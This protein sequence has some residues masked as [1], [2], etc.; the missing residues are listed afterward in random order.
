MKKSITAIII[1]LIFMT[2]SAS[3]SILGSV[4]KESSSLP[5][6]QGLVLNYNKFLSDQNGVGN[7]SEYYAEYT[8]NTSAVPVVLTGEDIYGKRDANEAIEYMKNN[9]M[10]PMLGINAS[11][12]SFQTGIPMGHVIT[13]GAVTSK[14]NRSLP[15]IGFR[16]DSTAFIEDMYIETNA[17]FGENY[18]LQIPHINKFISSETQMLTLFTP[19]F[20]DKTGVS[21]ETLNVVLENVTDKVRVGSEFKCTVGKIFKSSEPVELKQGQYVLSVNTNGNQW[22]ITLIN[23]MYE[24]EEITVRTT[25]GNEIWNEAYNGLASEGEQIL[26]KGKVAEGLEAGASPRT[27]VGIK[28]NGNIIFYVIDGRQYGYSYGARKDTVAKRLIELGCVDALNLDGGGSTTMAGVY[29]G[30]DSS[31]IVNSPSEGALRKV[32]NFIFI[33]NASEAVGKPEMAYIYP[34]SGNILS[35]STIQL[36]V[37]TV[38][39][40]YYPT[41]HGEVSYSCNEYGSVSDGGE[42]TALGE[43]A[44]RVE[45][46]TSGLTAAAVYK[47]YITPDNIRLYNAQNSAELTQIDVAQGDTVYLKAESF[48]DGTRLLSSNSAY[49]WTVSN[50][51]I[52][53]DEDGVMTVSD[54]FV[55][56]AVLTLKAGRFTRDFKIVCSSAPITP[57]TYPYSEIAVSNNTLTVDMFSYYDSLSKTKSYVRIDGEKYSIDEA[58]DIDARHIRARIALDE[59]FSDGN[60]RIFAVTV[61]NNGYSAVNS[62][63][64]MNTEEANPFADTD[65]HWAKNII[66]YMNKMGV[67]NGSEENG[68][69]CY[70]PDGRVTRAEFAVMAVN[71]L[72]LDLSEYDDVLLDQFADGYLIPEWAANHIKAA[73]RNGII[74]GKSEADGL[75]FAPY[76]PITR[77]EA[78]TIISRML[79]SKL[80]AGTVSFADNNSIPAWAKRPVEILTSAGLLKGYEDNTLKPQN[81]VTRAE[82]VTMLYNIF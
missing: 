24:G 50:T 59:G 5:V 72:K 64:V 67:V 74:S 6:G 18:I 39:E 51:G 38:D 52:S 69:F 36:D 11:Y 32:T 71:F 9:D 42:L 27:A 57:E 31:V 17:S 82:A 19:D 77:A 66:S 14:D 29:P 63:S 43:G 30:C 61:L 26:S 16:K 47:T 56:V 70:R 48:Y 25:A 10:V 12:F 13:D 41:E 76:E 7:Q 44:V 1:L 79:P 78:A 45:A 73:Y 58:E 65:S 15:G 81:T 20:G 49:R 35:G 4:L 55:G 21:T 62:L 60:H 28:E 40:N 54:Y 37:K 80:K 46:K 34:Y 75:Y 8:P 68:V 53:V 3:A 33:K 23:T 2:N 22:A